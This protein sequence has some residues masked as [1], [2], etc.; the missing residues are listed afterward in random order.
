VIEVISSV[1]EVEK[2][3]RFAKTSVEGLEKF[4]KAHSNV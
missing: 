3:P 2:L 4:T 1:E